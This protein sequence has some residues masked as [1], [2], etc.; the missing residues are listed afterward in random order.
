MIIYSIQNKINRKRYIGQS[1]SGDEHE[2]TRP[3]T[4][5]KG[6]GSKL[7]AHAVQKYGEHNFLVE[8]LYYTPEYDK[9]LLD[10]KEIHY[11]AQYNA[12]SPNGYN[13]TDGGGGTVGIEVSLECRQKQS[14]ARRGK[15]PFKDKTPDEL[16]AIYAKRKQSRKPINP[17]ANKTP[18][19]MELINKKKSE[20]SKL[21][22]NTPEKKAWMSERQTG[23]N[24]YRNKSAEEMEAIGKRQSEKLKEYFKHNSAYWK[25][26][27]L[28]EELRNRMSEIQ[29]EVAKRPEIKLRNSVAGGIACHRRWHVKIGKFNP[30]CVHCVEESKISLVA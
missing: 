9:K 21:I 27:H 29:K 20:S 10:E 12:K 5:L 6:K 3:L 4:H 24:N 14:K 28:P 30:N 18:E 8:I 7:I 15:F 11:I 26:K 16:A 17:Y 1:K 2:H 13:L 23:V 22:W 25:D 19:E